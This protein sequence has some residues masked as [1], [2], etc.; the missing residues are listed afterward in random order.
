MIEFI[1]GLFL[2]AMLGMMLMCILAMSE[3]DC[4]GDCAQ[5]K[6]CT[7]RGNK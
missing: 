5:G 2:G 6:N 1:C 7:C 3:T 4:T